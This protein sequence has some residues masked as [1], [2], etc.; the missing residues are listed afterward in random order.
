MRLS[1]WIAAL[2]FGPLTRLAIE[3]QFSNDAGQTPA[4][5][6]ISPS[7]P[8]SPAACSTRHRAFFT[9]TETLRC[10]AGNQTLAHRLDAIGDDGG[11]VFGRRSAPSVSTTASVTLEVAIDSPARP[12]K[13]KIT[14]DY[15][16]LAIPPSLWPA[17]AASK[18]TIT[19]ELSREAYVSMG[20]A[21]K[22]LSPLRERF[23]IGQG[24]RRPPRPA[25][26]ASPGKAPTTRLRSRARLELNLFAGSNVARSALDEFDRGGENAVHAFYAS[27]IGAVYKGYT[28]NLSATPDFVAWPR[29]PW[30]H[31][32]YS[33]PAP[34]EVCRAGPLLTAAF[35]KRMFFAGEHT[36]FA[37]FGYMEG[38][39][40]SGQRA[41]SSIIAALASQEADER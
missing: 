25:S 6:V 9:Q 24:W 11:T 35:H 40:Q 12:G 2:R 19:P 26:L 7:S 29:D 36:C 32:G 31:A 27:R 34:G 37:Y 3:E 8:S 5:K 13:R 18:I 30:T 16:I 4:G 21:M 38:A 41:A 23:W 1:D 20:T 10:S 39:L 14:A 15:V 22:Y 28:N 17:A 33:C